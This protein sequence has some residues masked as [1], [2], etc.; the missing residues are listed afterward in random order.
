[1]EVNPRVPACVKS[2]FESGIDWADVI[3]CEYLKKPHT[4]YEMSREVYLRFLGVEIL[5]FLK[6]KNR[7]KTFPNWFKFWGRN[8]FYQDMSDWS[9]PLPFICGTIGNI[10]K[11]FSPK[12]RKA[13]SGI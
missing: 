9:D 2:A 3:V 11:Q 13:K 10:I 6:S 4:T 7:W 5:W 8:I 12:F 1:M